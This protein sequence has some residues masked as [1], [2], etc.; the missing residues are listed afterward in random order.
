VGDL[1]IQ[2]GKHHFSILEDLYE[3]KSKLSQDI[4]NFV[5]R[6]SS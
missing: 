1:L 4:V 2:E 5:K 3:A 6:N